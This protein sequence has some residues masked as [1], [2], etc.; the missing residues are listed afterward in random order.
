ICPAGGGE[1]RKPSRELTRGMELVSTRRN[2]AVQ[3]LGLMRSC[4]L[5]HTSREARTE[6]EPMLRNPLPLAVLLA[7]AL[8]ARAGPAH[9]QNGSTGGALELYPTLQSVGVRLA[10]TGD[11]N[12]N[13]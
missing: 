11:A 1:S 3:C 13:A 9:A 7:A 12:A 6:S 5:H 2:L 10:Y 8:L 4:S